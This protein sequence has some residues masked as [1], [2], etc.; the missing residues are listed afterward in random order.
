LAEYYLVFKKIYAHFKKTGRI[1]R[2]S[3]LNALRKARDERARWVSLFP[4][5]QG[6]ELSLL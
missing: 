6:A 5:C 2:I 4:Y 1:W 3:K